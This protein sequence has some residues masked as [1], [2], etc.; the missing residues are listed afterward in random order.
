[1]KMGVLVILSVSLV[2]VAWCVLRIDM[3]GDN[4][5]IW[6]LARNVFNKQFWTVNLKVFFQLGN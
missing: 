4:L 2:M 6:R 5:Q 3:G 1:M